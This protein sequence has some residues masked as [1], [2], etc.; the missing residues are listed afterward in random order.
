MNHSIL[1]DNYSPAADFVVTAICFVMIILL[2]V[3]YV[4]RTRSSVLFLS[5]VGLVLAAAW[6]DIL[7][8]TLAVKPDHLVLANWIR[9]FY[10]ALLFLIFVHYVA[11][12][13]EITHYKNSRI[14][15][16]LA[17]V[18]FAAVLLADII[19]T[20]QGPTFYLVETGIRFVRRGIF[21]YAYIG[22]LVLCLLLM[23]RVSN[24]LFRPVMIGFYGTMG[25]S[26]L[27]LL[28]QGMMGQ[29]SFTVAGLQLPVIAM[30]YI[31]HS[32][33]YDAELGTN[34]IRAL[35]DMVK[36]CS[37]KKK[38]FMFM[39]LYMWELDEEGKEIP[40][41]MKRLIWQLAFRFF[42]KVRL[43]TVSRGHVVLIFPK[44]QNPDYEKGIQ[45]MLDTFFPLYEKFGYDYKIV[46]GES[47][48]EISLSG[49]AIDYIASIH[50][51]MPECSVHRVIPEDIRTFHRYEYI[52]NELADIYK[53]QDPDDPRVLVYCQPVKNVET[54]DFDT[55]EALMRLQ[56]DET[57]IVFPD[58]FIPLAEEEEYIHALT[59]IILHKTCMA[60]RSFTEAGYGIRR[61]SVNVSAEE[62]KEKSFCRDILGI[63]ERCGVSGE[64]IAIEL[65]E[66]RSERDFMLM[67]EKIEELK[68]KGLTFYLDDFGTG[69]SN[70]ERILELP[71]DIIKFDR[72]LVQ[73]AATDERSRMMV[74]NL[75]NMFTSMNFDVLYEGVER[76]ADE[77]L[78]LEMSAA[79]LQGYQYSRP[80]PIAEL[81]NYLSRKP[82]PAGGDKEAS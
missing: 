18:L 29:S 53:K 73:A 1:L 19:T 72:T 77:A 21:F 47:V 10:H 70:M 81:S 61:I 13:C 79:Y 17:N 67:K 51:T 69:Y 15:L 55:A 31:L 78:C 2:A 56:L 60:V 43:F 25:V 76:D 24:I 11:Y 16:L 12:I 27:L 75:S 34:D 22:F 54:G 7:F 48:D 50:R 45:K 62:L 40:D 33:P 32:N 52:L 38:D 74:S 6:T 37:E 3:S 4:S 59:E 44:K 39:S 58:Q 20:A 9:C 65:T 28:L 82:S 68:G 49:E 14:Y 5:M 42:R 80:V 23:A 46:I 8:Y 41:E 64:Q 63:L 26:L 71:F 66:S 36:Y 57:G 30:M 35:Q